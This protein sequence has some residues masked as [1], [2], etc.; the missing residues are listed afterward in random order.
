MFIYIKKFYLMS[1]TLYFFE[2]L[3]ENCKAKMLSTRINSVLLKDTKYPCED[4]DKRIM[5][6]MGLGKLKRICFGHL[7][8]KCNVT[9]KCNVTSIITN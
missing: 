2:R 5:K 6:K 3:Q 4:C 7:K 8:C 9:L 1:H